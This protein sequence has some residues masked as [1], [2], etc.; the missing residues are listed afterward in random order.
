MRDL[1]EMGYINCPA[2]V[3]LSRHAAGIRI[4]AAKEEDRT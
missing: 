1:R 4:T 2:E 3:A